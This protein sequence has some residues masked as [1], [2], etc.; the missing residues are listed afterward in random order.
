[1]KVCYILRD[2][3]QGGKSLEEIFKRIIAFH[4]DSLAVQAEIFQYDSTRSLLSNLQRLRRIKADIYH[5]TGSVHFL[6]IFLRRKPTILTVHDLG[7]FHR[8]LKGVKKLL[9]GIYNVYLPLLLSTR[10]SVISKFTRDELLRTLPLLAKKM[11]VIHNPY[12]RLFRP[13]PK[14]EENGTLKILQIGT[15][16][17]KNVERVVSALAGLDCQLTILGSLSTSLKECLTKSKVD[18]SSLKNLSYSEVYK[19]YCKADIIMFPS[20]FEGFGMPIIEAN[21]VGRPVI[22]SNLEPMLEIG[23]EAAL[24]VDPY[25]VNSIKSAV[26]RLQDDLDLAKHLIENGYQNIKRFEIEEIA[27]QYY[28]LYQSVIDEH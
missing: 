4:E 15:G 18:Y 11:V 25:D 26:I 8:T 17:N 14:V 21:A 19:L 12:P 24:F 3:R 7:H 20:T 13:S 9:Y 28:Q 5:N 16:A 10:I 2:S 27:R 22:T 6:N 23:G 1:M